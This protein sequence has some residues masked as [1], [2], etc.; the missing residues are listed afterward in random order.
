MSLCGRRSST[1]T[2]RWTMTR[3]SPEKTM[4]SPTTMIPSCHAGM[5]WTR[6]TIRLPSTR[7]SVS[8][9]ADRSAAR[10]GPAPSCERVLR[11][12]GQP[13]LQFPDDAHRGVDVRVVRRP[14]EVVTPQGTAIRFPSWR[15]C[16]L[17][18]SNPR[19]GS[20]L[21]GRLFTRQM[22]KLVRA[23]VVLSRETLEASPRPETEHRSNDK[24][25]AI[26]EACM[27]VAQ[28]LQQR[29]ALRVVGRVP[30]HDIEGSRADFGRRE[31][32]KLLERRGILPLARPRHCTV[33]SDASVVMIMSHRRSA[34]DPLG[35]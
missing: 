34:R 15:S 9:P 5:P 22:S 29:Q 25:V 10:S 12:R 13:P 7:L 27:P 14:D 24:L 28:E 4:D 18:H 2:S 30:F 20:H 16:P 3:P 23:T 26:P 21:T 35:R 32:L 8:W 31:T 11:Q 6:S 19:G 1:G 17:G 33:I